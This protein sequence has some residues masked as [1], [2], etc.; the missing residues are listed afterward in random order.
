MRTLGTPI[1]SGG[2]IQTL[3][4]PL[5]LCPQ[6]EER[7]KEGAAQDKNKNKAGSDLHPKLHKR[8]FLS[9]GKPILRRI[10]G[11]YNTLL[12]KKA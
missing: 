11:T 9:S 6:K 2:Q 8:G 10:E 5:F 3:D 7:E 12:D 4:A 1:L